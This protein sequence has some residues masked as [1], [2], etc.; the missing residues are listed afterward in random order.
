MT[1]HVLQHIFLPFPISFRLLYTPC[2]QA[3]P[4]L[5]GSKAHALSQVLPHHWRKLTSQVRLGCP[6]LWSGCLPCISS[7][8]QSPRAC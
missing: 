1:L 8:L 3:A 5:V 2:S 7:W 6:Q 4:F